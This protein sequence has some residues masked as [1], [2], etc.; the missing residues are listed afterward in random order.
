VT[1]SPFQQATPSPPLRMSTRTQ[2][3][4][5]EWPILRDVNVP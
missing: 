5:V 3:L 4:F 1:A 2:H